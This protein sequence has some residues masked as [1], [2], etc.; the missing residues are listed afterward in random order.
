[1]PGGVFVIGHPSSEHDAEGE[2][3][4]GEDERAEQQD[5]RTPLVMLKLR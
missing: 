5:S 4:G 3:D 1:M 2:E